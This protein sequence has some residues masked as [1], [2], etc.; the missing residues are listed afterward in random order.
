MHEHS[1]TNEVVHRILHACED[2]GVSPKKITVELGLLSGYKKDPVLF[3]FESIKKDHDV[4]SQAELDIVEVKGRILCNQCGLDSDVEPSP[5]IICPACESADVKI[6]EGD[7]I[8]IR[9]IK[10]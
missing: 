3:Y 7:K 8:V 4:L 1:I 5:L 6:L 2:S 9:E 10:D